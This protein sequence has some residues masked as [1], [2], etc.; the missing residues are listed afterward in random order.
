MKQFLLIVFISVL[1]FNQTSAQES[2]I[3]LDTPKTVS[4]IKPQ[5][6]VVLNTKKVETPSPIVLNKKAFKNKINLKL[7]GKINLFNIKQRYNL[8]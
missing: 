8:C 5:S 3:N 4:C 2:N 1:S 6:V 7:K